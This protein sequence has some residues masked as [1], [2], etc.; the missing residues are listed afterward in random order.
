MACMIMSANESLHDRSHLGQIWGQIWILR[1][2]FSRKGHPYWDNRSINKKVVQKCQCQCP[3]LEKWVYLSF[4]NYCCIVIF[5]VSKKCTKY[6]F[7]IMYGAIQNRWNF[8][9]NLKNKRVTDHQ[10]SVILKTLI[11]NNSLV[12]QDINLKFYMQV[13]W[14]YIYKRWKIDANRLNGFWENRSWPFLRSF[15]A[16]F[17]NFFFIYPF[18]RQNSALFV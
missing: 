7:K 5:C 10:R 12:G 4:L 11:N 15:L 8:F 2:Q 14:G 13:V 1:G 3:Q 18:K 17:C 6:D 9:H 16:I